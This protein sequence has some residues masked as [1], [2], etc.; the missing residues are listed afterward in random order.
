[1]EHGTKTGSGSPGIIG[2]TDPTPGAT[3]LADRLTLTVPFTIFVE[4]E[5]EVPA[6]FLKK[7]TWSKSRSRLNTKS[8]S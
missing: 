1:M 4:M 8:S 6:S 5:E 7:K 3:L 2:N